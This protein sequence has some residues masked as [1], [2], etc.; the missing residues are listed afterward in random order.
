MGS[1]I[2]DPGQDSPWSINPEA[3]EVLESYLLYGDVSLV[4]NELHIPKQK[5]TY[6]LGRPESKRFLDTIYFEQGYLNRNRLQDILGEV[7]DLKLEEMRESEIGSKKDIA[8]LIALAHKI[9][10]D[11]AKISSIGTEQS[12]PKTQTNV[13]INNAAGF[14]DNYN[15]L[16]EKIMTVEK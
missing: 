13:Q 2:L 3:M 16:L 15:S 10:A 14:G 9:R 6:Y 1:A 8:D 7:M 5:V 4:A 12:G 11:E